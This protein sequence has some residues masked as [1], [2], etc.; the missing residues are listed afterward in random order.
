MLFN[1]H[2][3]TGAKFIHIDSF[4]RNKT[5][6]WLYL[7]GFVGVDI[8]VS[9]SQAYLSS[10]PNCLCLMGGHVETFYVCTH[11]HAVFYMPQPLETKIL[12]NAAPSSPASSAR[13]T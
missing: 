5:S 1:V 11:A 4:F 13:E 6:L 7:C 12:Q 2:T 10:L 3:R 9:E 8:L